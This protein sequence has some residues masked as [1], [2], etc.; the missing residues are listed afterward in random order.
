MEKFLERMRVRFWDDEDDGVRN[1]MRF[2]ITKLEKGWQKAVR[3]ERDN[4]DLLGK[5]DAERVNV[6]QR[7]ERIAELQARI[8]QMDDNT[9]AVKTLKAELEESQKAI[10]ERDD[11]INRLA[12]ELDS[13]IARKEAEVDVLQNK[14]DSLNKQV[15]DLLKSKKGWLQKI[16]GGAK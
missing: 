15:E 9:I 1:D 6:A 10:A 12:D 11:R 8:D 5:V 13:F 4:D 7:E 14:I 2:L 16:I 3:V